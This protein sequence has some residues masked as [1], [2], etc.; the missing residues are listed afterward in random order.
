MRFSALLCIFAFPV[1][2]QD[3][4]PHDLPDSPA[5]GRLFITN[6]LTETV[7]EY[8]T[9]IVGG[10]E[11]TVHYHSTPNHVTGVDPRDIVTVTVPDGYVAIPSD[12]LLPE[13]DTVEILIYEAL[14]G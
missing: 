14:L 7:D 5:L 8:S 10:V 1:L 3:V 6:H 13:G 12:V 9:H 2:A 11:V 4:R